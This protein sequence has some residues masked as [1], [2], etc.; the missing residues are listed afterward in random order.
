VHDIPPPPPPP[1]E[2][3]PP[4]R[5]GMS[6]GLRGT[7]IAIVIIAVVVIGIIGYAVAGFAYASSRAAGANRSLN[8]V[9][10]HQNSIN[11]TFKDIDTKFSGLNS[12]SS[13]DPKAARALVDQ[14]VTN[15]AA[16]GATVDQDDASL[17]SARASL[18]E[19]QWLTVLS[20]GT[21]DQEAQRIDHA[22]KGLSIAKTIASGYVQDGQF[23]QSFLDA[24]ADLDTFD[25]QVATADLTAAKATLATMKTHTDKALQLASSP[26]LPADLHNLVV[27]FQTLVADFGKLID[28]VASGDV[29]AITNASQ[30]IDKDATKVSSY[31][32]VKISTD[33]DTYYKPLVDT[34]NSEMQKAT[35]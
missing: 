29:N 30:A 16:V 6:R 11:T 14:F 19:Q 26:G 12:N 2:T 8:T 33:I 20:K 5:T 27:D 13:S 10:S 3:T 34:F 23:L 4:A 15:A 32:F 22:R 24:V 28:A 1:F 35:A 9:V 31:N 21:L 25:T 18:D 17:V 7:I